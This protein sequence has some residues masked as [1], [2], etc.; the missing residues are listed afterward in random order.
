M[1][2]WYIYWKF[3]K[4]VFEDLQKWYFNF[5]NHLPMWLYYIRFWS[6][7]P[8]YNAQ[9]ISPKFSLQKL[10]TCNKNWYSIVSSLI[11]TKNIQTLAITFKWERDFSNSN[12]GLTGTFKKSLLVW[13]ISK[14]GEIQSAT[15]HFQDW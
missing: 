3:M 10:F 7:S 15:S 6:V 8:H 1:K 12:V 14:H 9:S 11:R 4:K 13:C 5:Y 2:H